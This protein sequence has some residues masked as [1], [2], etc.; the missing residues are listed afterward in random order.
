M[1]VTKP[2]A[3]EWASSSNGADS[4]ALVPSSGRK[5]SGYDGT[6]FPEFVYENWY[7]R[8]IM[9]WQQWFDQQEQ[10]DTAHIG[11]LESNVTAL[12][13]TSGSFNGVFQSAQT[14][15][16]NYIKY[17]NNRVKLWWGDSLSLTS[18]NSHRTGGSIIPTSILPSSGA[19]RYVFALMQTGV[20]GVPGLVQLMNQGGGSPPWAGDI[21]LGAVDGTVATTGIFAGIGEYF[22]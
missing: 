15:T 1:P 20:G 16:F 18:G 22:I 3:L 19:D 12:Q 5:A 14:I 6:T 4:I 7:K 9:L 13:G 21:L 11:T 2:S 10:Y 17:S 8:Q